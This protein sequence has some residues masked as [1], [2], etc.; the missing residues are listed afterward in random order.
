M[1]N[2]DAIYGKKMFILSFHQFP[3]NT[4]HQIDIASGERSRKQI[5]SNDESVF[6]F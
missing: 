2:V 3:T 4:L 1:Q 5:I 6:Q